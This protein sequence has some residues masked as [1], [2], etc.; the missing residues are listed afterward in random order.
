MIT[1]FTWQGSDTGLQKLAYSNQQCANSIAATAL[2]QA[3][4]SHPCWAHAVETP[5]RVDALMR[6]WPLNGAFINI[7]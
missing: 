4:T 3:I 2:L 7:L 6:A 5:F 1:S